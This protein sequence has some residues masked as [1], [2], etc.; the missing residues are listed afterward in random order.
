LAIWAGHVFTRGLLVFPNHWDSLAYHIPLVNRW[1]QTGSLYTPDFS[2][3]SQPGNNELLEL[4]AVAPFSGDFLVNLG[5]FPVAVLLLYGTLGLARELGLS[6]LFSRLTA[7]AVAFTHVT[8]GQLITSENDLAVAALTVAALA[9]G[10]RCT[11]RCSP[12]DEVGWAASLGLLAGVK[13]YAL[14]YAGVVGTVI[15]LQTLRCRGLSAALRI[16]GIG[17]LGILL[18]SGY[19]YAR[20]TLATGSP[21]YPL[22]ASPHNND[23]EQFYPNIWKST[24]LGN[25]HPEVP[26]LTLLAVGRIAGPC[27]LLALS[28][29]PAAAGWLWFV[30]RHTLP[31]GQREVGRAFV[32]AAIGAGAVWLVTPFAVEC[33]P[34]TLNQLRFERTPVRYGLTFL[35][36]AIVAVAAAAEPA[37]N[38]RTWRVLI[39]GLLGTLLAAQF[40]L[41]LVNPKRGLTDEVMRGL[42]VQVVDSTLFALIVLLA[43]CAVILGRQIAQR[44][45]TYALA[46]SIAVAAGIGGA[47]LSF[48]WHKGFEEHYTRMFEDGVFAFLAR[49][50]LPDGAKVCVLDERSYPFFGSRRQFRVSVPLL[51]ADAAGLRRFLDDHGIEVVVVRAESNHFPT[52]VNQNR[53]ATQWIENTSLRLV[54]LRMGPNYWVFR[55][56]DTLS[57]Q[58]AGVNPSPPRLP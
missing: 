31:L 29:F 15:A 26:W 1:L 16:S 6:P 18:L 8:L 47:A 24:F 32:W 53:L 7:L 3:W 36:L 23:V 43:S 49:S 38:K 56:G 37:A 5:N 9:T 45:I 52:S 42:Q 17:L 10:L 20:N 57:P 54:P 55:V 21:L 13:F 35:S 41:T 11:R 44:W 50:D 34:G 30:G 22:G 12:G 33:V 39:G 48:T 25:G 27:H 4:W 28:V 14:G 2:Y 40:G 19:W 46:A 58:A 51:L